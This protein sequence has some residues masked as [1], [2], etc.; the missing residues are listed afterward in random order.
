M[1][2]PTHNRRSIAAPTGTFNGGTTSISRPNNTITSTDP[3]NGRT[4][5][6]SRQNSRSSTRNSNSR[7][8]DQNNS[9]ENDSTRIITVNWEQYLPREL[10][11]ILFPPPEPVLHPQHV[12]QLEREAEKERVK[13]EEIETNERLYENKKKQKARLTRT[14]GTKEWLQ[15]FY[16]NR[17]FPGDARDRELGLVWGTI[18]FNGLHPIACINNTEYKSGNIR[19]YRA[20]IGK[21][22]KRDGAIRRPCSGLGVDAEQIVKSYSLLSVDSNDV[23]YRLPAAFINCSVN[24]EKPEWKIYHVVSNEDFKLY[25]TL[26]VLQNEMA[27]FTQV[28][29]EDDGSGIVFDR[30]ETIDDTIETFDGIDIEPEDSGFVVDSLTRKLMLAKAKDK[31]E[32][33]FKLNRKREKNKRNAERMRDNSA[34]PSPAEEMMT[35]YDPESGKFIGYY[36]SNCELVLIS[37]DEQ[38]FSNTNMVNKID[39][40]ESDSDDQSSKSEDINIDNYE[41]YSKE[42]TKKCKGKRDNGKTNKSNTSSRGSYSI[43]NNNYSLD[44]L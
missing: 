24:P 15:K 33:D 19:W 17:I 5:S 1:N 6:N 12:K 36:N 13:Q 28:I 25:R 30:E 26:G 4:T 7:G 40:S 32:S 43:D 35:A 41:S 31:I 29:Y 18:R 44:D 11:N 23:I 42:N 2:P 21:G 38:V 37:D 9:I 3:V 39:S 34:T 27:Q 14:P 22:R 10:Y 16:P 20:T 8:T